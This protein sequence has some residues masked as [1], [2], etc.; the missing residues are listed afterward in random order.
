VGVSSG[1]LDEFLEYQGEYEYAK[2]C[3]D[4]LWE[5]VDPVPEYK[6][7]SDYEVRGKYGR[8]SRG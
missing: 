4:V 1:I 8:Q 6:G 2:L 5:L 7:L 3:Y